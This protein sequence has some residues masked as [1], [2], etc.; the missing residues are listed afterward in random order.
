MTSVGCEE[1][2][3]QDVTRFGVEKKRRP[4]KVSLNSESEKEKV[5]KNLTRLKGNETYMRISITE[6]YT[7]SERKIV[8][9]LRDQVKLKNDEEPENSEFVYKLRG[10]P[11]NGLQIR[12]FK[13]NKNDLAR[14]SAEKTMATEETE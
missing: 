9:E 3:P 10:T 5:I 14:T 8:Q 7:V 13:K 2:K 12:R 1:I 11:K 4:I 6:D